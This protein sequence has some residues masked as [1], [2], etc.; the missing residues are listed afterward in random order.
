MI[1]GAHIATSNYTEFGSCD[2]CSG[3]QK[4]EIPYILPECVYE[5]CLPVRLLV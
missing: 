5:P 3:P 1:C 4:T 2:R